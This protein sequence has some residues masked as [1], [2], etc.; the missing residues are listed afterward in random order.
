MLKVEKES[1]KQ[2][3]G[4]E[5]VNQSAEYK[6]EDAG[7]DIHSSNSTIVTDMSSKPA[8]DFNYD[9]PTGFTDSVDDEFDDYSRHARKSGRRRKPPIDFDLDGEMADDFE[10]TPGS[11]DFNLFPEQRRRQ[12]KKQTVQSLNELSTELKVLMLSDIFD[13]RF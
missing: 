3:K 2:S 12:D 7:I 9:A 1:N 11:P 4:K 5:E 6:P 8:E 10:Y 13:R